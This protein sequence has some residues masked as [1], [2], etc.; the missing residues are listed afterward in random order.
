M[1]VVEEFAAKLGISTEELDDMFLLQRTVVRDVI[2]PCQLW[3]L[4]CCCGC[5]SAYETAPP[6]VVVGA[7]PNMHQQQTHSFTAASQL[8]AAVQ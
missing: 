4:C 6:P 8:Q 1:P 2:M 5:M 3:I 7:L